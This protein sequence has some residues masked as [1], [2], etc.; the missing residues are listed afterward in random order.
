MVPEQQV[1][2]GFNDDFGDTLT[3]VTSDGDSI[4]IVKDV[5]SSDQ[6]AS[7]P[8]SYWPTGHRSTGSSGTEQLGVS[9]GG[10]SYQTKFN[11]SEGHLDG[12]IW[13]SAQT[14]PHFA[15]SWGYADATEDQAPS[16]CNLRGASME[17]GIA[18]RTS[19]ASARP[20]VR[21][22]TVIYYQKNA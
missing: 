19:K 8:I 16:V 12:D 22:G 14:P 17:S 2:D 15:G 7:N 13:G 1:H 20:Q 21:F 4:C 18:F 5:H 3:N 11:V 6:A 10:A 9:A